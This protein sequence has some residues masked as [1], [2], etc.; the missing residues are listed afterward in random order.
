[1]GDAVALGV[2]VTFGVGV[3]VIFGV[4]VGDAFGAAILS[5]AMQMLTA[6]RSEVKKRRDVMA[7]LGAK[8]AR[9]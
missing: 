5:D 6:V 4:G 1:V 9:C 8:R 7:Q 2:G 3:G